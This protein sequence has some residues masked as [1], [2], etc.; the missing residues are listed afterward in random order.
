MARLC[1]GCVPDKQQIL[2]NL[3]CAFTK[4]GLVAAPLSKS[5]AHARRP[6]DALPRRPCAADTCRRAARDDAG[7]AAAATEDVR[8]RASPR[9]HPLGD[10][11][12][13]LHARDNT[14]RGA[15]CQI[16]S[17][18]AWVARG[19]WSDVADL[20]GAFESASRPTSEQGQ[21]SIVELRALGAIFGVSPAGQTS[22]R[23]LTTPIF[24]IIQGAIPQ[25]VSN[26]LCWGFLHAFPT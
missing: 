18:T 17:P 19:L 3:G 12:A 6:A 9:A 21:L 24:D 22:C 11:V 13:A 8:R 23:P 15:W 26:D 25:T 10:G 14:R 20:A 5:S 2:T 7:A 4:I 16:A 1:Q